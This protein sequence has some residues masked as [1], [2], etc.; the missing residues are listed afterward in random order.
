MATTWPE[1]G[2][3]VASGATRHAIPPVPPK[4]VQS[5]PQ[6]P[7]SAIE[8]PLLAKQL[9]QTKQTTPPCL[10]PRFAG[11][12]SVGN[13]PERRFLPVG[14]RESGKA[15]LRFKPRGWKTWKPDRLPD[16][17]SCWRWLLAAT[18]IRSQCEDYLLQS[19]VKQ[20]V[21]FLPADE[22]GG[23]VARGYLATKP[24]SW[25]SPRCGGRLLR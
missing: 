5:G 18:F 3:G 16:S 1:G 9:S 25:A 11:H 7:K 6:P 20:R 23:D 13:G 8:S 17:E 10:S 14:R 21:V 2:L 4:T 22:V 15:A 12:V 24:L 19:P